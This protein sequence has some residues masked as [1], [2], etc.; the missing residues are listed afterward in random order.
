ML[1]GPFTQLLTMA[2]LPLRGP[3]ADDQLEIIPDAGIVVRNGCIVEVGSFAE[4]RIRYA[5]KKLVPVERNLVAFPGMIDAH[6]HLCWAGSR[7]A[8]YALRLS[9]KSYLEIAT[10]GGGI[11]DTVRKTRA[12]TSDELV[13]LT[14]QRANLLLSRGITTIEVKSGYGLTVHHE[15]K[16]LEAI[17]DANRQTAADLVPTCLAAHVVPP[18]YEKGSVVSEEKYLTGR[19]NELLPEVKRRNLA[20]RVD[21]FI[22]KGAF[23]EAAARYYLQAA[24]DRGFDLVIHGDQFTVGAAAVANDLHA[25]SID[26]LEAAGAKEISTLAQGSTIAVALPGASLGLGEPFAP[27]RKLLDA[28][29]ALAIASDWNPGSAPMGNLLAQAAI[30]GAAQQLSTAEVWAAITY[31]AAAALKLGDRGK[32]QKGMKAD[33]IAFQTNDYREVLYRQGELRPSI[34]IKNGKMLTINTKQL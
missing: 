33:I 3:I 13:Q 27:A 21:V 5:E 10:A 23:S 9:G 17:A 19:L 16:I 24:R 14:L 7:A 29:N 2:S 28:G 32:L 11:L 1:I 22:E 15:L 4:L 31:R 12:A 25:L 26:H 30:L 34:V 6:T 18:E 20:S 8:D